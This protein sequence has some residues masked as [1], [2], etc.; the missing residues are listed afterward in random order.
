MISASS[1]Q[2][3][4]IDKLFNKTPVSAWRN[5]MVEYKCIGRWYTTDNI[6]DLHTHCH[7][8]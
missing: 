4:V 3:S 7:K 1:K 5:M 6:P 8:L 2:L